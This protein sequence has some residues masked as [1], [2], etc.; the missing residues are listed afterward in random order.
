MT[1]PTNTEIL[2]LLD[3]L[4]T[5]VADDLESEVLEFKPWRDAKSESRC[6]NVPPPALAAT[7]QREG[8]RR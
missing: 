2:T 1:P 3:K 7:K 8:G 4:A 5:Q 6:S